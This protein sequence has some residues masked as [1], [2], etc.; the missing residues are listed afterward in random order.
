MVEEPCVGIEHKGYVDLQTQDE[1][2]ELEIDDYI[3]TYQYGDSESPL[4]GSPLIDQVVETDIL[5]GYLLPGSVYSDE[6]PLLI[7]R[8]DHNT[9]MDTSV[10]DPRA[11]EISRVS[12]QEDTTTHT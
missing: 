3:H 10:W 2:H 4:L 5:L 6:D 1:R 7:G 11:Y 9:Y 8:D 12:E